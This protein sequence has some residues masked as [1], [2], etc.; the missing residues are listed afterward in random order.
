MYYSSIRLQQDPR[1]ASVISIKT[2]CE[3]GGSWPAYCCCSEA[4]GVFCCWSWL[5][6]LRITRVSSVA[7]DGTALGLGDP[8][9]FIGLVSPVWPDTIFR[10]AN[11]SLLSAL[12]VARLLQ[13]TCD[14]TGEMLS[15]QTSGFVPTAAHFTNERA[16]ALHPYLVATV[17]PSR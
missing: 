5:L 14:V 11:L 8:L 3:V 6:Q 2:S 15:S 17:I 13:M 12:L 16:R 4:S 7:N 1:S 9:V 10:I